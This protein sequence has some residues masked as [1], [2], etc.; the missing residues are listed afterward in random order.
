MSGLLFTRGGEGG[1]GPTEKQLKGAIPPLLPLWYLDEVTLNGPLAFPGCHI[2]SPH[3]TDTLHEK[4]IVTRR[5]ICR[6]WE[7]NAGVHNQIFT[8]SYAFRAA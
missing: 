2:L 5:I 8:L 4:H 3:E 6:F 7:A 1:Q